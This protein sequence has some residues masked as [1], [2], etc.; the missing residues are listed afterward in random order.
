[1]LNLTVKG[2]K[3]LQD[4]ASDL[5]GGKG[6]LRSELTTAFRR[7]GNSTLQRVKNNMLTMQMTGYRTGAAKTFT[8]ARTGTGIRKRIARVTELD[9]R[10]GTVDPRVK[11]EVKVERLGNARELPFYLDSG[12]RFRHPIMGRRSRWAA[13]SGKPWFRK[14]IRSDLDRFRAECDAAITRTVL[15]IEKG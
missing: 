11:F 7:A 14:E 15:K 6:T 4:L 13:Q 3:Q 9:I 12:K 2:S 5:R 1:V 8:D 10:T